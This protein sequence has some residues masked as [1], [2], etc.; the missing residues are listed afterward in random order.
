MVGA[1]FVAGTWASVGPLDAGCLFGGLLE[2]G[3]LFAG[4][5]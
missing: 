2:A 5:L 1:L 4:T 3:G